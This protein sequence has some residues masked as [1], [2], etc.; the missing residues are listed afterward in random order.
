MGKRLIFFVSIIIFIGCK[1]SVHVNNQAKNFE[2]LTL[3]INL[4]INIDTQLQLFYI[5]EKGEE[6]SEIKSF[7]TF[8]KKAD[9]S[10]EVLLSFKDIDPYSI[11][12]DFGDN[13]ALKEISIYSVKVYW[14][15]NNVEFNNVEKY[16][17][18]NL[19]MKKIDNNKYQLRILRDVI[20]DV[21]DPYM[22][23]NKNFIQSIKELK[24]K[25]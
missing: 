2:Y 12:I 21:Y 11:R 25:E 19:F 1:D 6:F 14:K 9:S 13:P 7:K 5:S 10:Q 4:K 20:Y 15:K 24:E 3:G 8:V 23:S 18:P 17:S 16:F 22:I